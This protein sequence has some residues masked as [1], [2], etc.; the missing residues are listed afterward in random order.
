M[1]TRLFL[2][3]MLLVRLD[4]ALSMEPT[5]LELTVFL[6]WSSLDVLVPR[7]LLKTPNQGRLL[8]LSLTT[9]ARHP[10]LTLTSSDTPTEGSTLQ[11]SDSRCRKPCRLML[12]FSELVQS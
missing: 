4:V 8:D 2:V 11:K 1:G 12:Q 10:L 9:L 6:T 5:D 7:P 3:S